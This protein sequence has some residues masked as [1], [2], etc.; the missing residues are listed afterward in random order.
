MPTLLKKLKMANEKNETFSWVRYKPEE[1]EAL[2]VKL[3]KEGNTTSQIGL[4]LRDSYGIPDTKTLTG[5]KI[6]QILVSKDIKKELPED[7]L[8]LIKKA[9]LIRKHLETNHKDVPAKRGIMITESKIKRLANY[10]KAQ[11]R[12]DLDWR[13]DPKKGAMFL[14]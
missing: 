3:S 4:I 2:V 1:I 7:L 10:Y 12:L 9:V 11:K 6:T 14:E 13:F 5:K 8:N